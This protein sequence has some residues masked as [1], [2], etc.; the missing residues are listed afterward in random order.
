VEGQEGVALFQLGL[1]PRAPQPEHRP[2]D[3]T[4]PGRL[5]AEGWPFVRQCLIFI[6]PVGAI[7]P[8]EHRDAQNPALEL[9]LEVKWRAFVRSVEATPHRAHQYCEHHHAQKS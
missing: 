1:S 8:L 5:L 9:G 7:P 2:N 6:G 3:R 4:P